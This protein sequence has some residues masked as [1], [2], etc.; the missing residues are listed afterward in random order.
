MPCSMILKITACT[1]GLS[2]QLLQRRNPI[3]DRTRV[4]KF[5]PS[6]TNLCGLNLLLEHRNLCFERRVFLIKLAPW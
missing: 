4:F 1:S 5:A 6:Y 2:L 3:S